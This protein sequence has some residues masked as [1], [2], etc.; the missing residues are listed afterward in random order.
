MKGLD[1]YSGASRG[2]EPSLLLPPDMR[3]FPSPL[4]SSTGWRGRAGRQHHAGR[5]ARKGCGAARIERGRPSQASG[6]G[7]VLRASF[8]FHSRA[9]FCASAICGGAIS[10][11]SLTNLQ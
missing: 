3:R 5:A 2:T 4:R 10:G 1:Q 8:G 7:Y 11:S 9:S 6:R